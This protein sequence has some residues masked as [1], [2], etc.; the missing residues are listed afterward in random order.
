[1]STNFE[2][3]IAL[4]LC[5]SAFDT[6]KVYIDC[7]RGAA[8]VSGGLLPG[9]VCVFYIVLIP[10]QFC[11]LLTFLGTLTVV[12]Q[13][14]PETGGE[15]AIAL[16][17]RAGAFDYHSSTCRNDMF[18]RQLP[19]EL[20]LALQLYCKFL[21]CSSLS[22][23]LGGAM[24]SAVAS[25]SVDQ[26]SAWRTQ[27]SIASINQSGTAPP[28][29]L[30]T[31]PV[32]AVQDDG[33]SDRRPRCFLSELVVRPEDTVCAVRAN[34]FPDCGRPLVVAEKSLV[35]QASNATATGQQGSTS[36]RGLTVHI[37]ARCVSTHSVAEAYALLY[38]WCLARHV[39]TTL[40]L[41][42]VDRTDC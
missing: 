31:G 27:S 32:L 23:G 18:T 37:I 28:R 5:G 15:A 4:G 13:D 30:Q 22:I 16:W 36:R 39:F 7:Y 6:I 33:W 20:L 14:C 8:A 25:M 34:V 24:E 17:L 41:P 21:P 11:G 42:G 3:Q 40:A 2:P 12:L 26:A 9:A 29:S 38:S 10:N 1:M 19:S 35:H